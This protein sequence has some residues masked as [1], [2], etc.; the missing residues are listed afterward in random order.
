MFGPERVAILHEAQRH[1]DR[2]AL[3]QVR[4][5]CHGR[6]VLLLRLSF[7]FGLHASNRFEEV[8]AEFDRA[9][10]MLVYESLQGLQFGQQLDLDRFFALGEELVVLQEEVFLVLAAGVDVRDR[11]AA[12]LLRQF[13]VLRFAQFAADC[14]DLAVLQH[15]VPALCLLAREFGLRQF[16][17]GCVQRRPLVQDTPDPRHPLRP[18]ARLVC[19]HAREYDCGRCGQQLLSSRVVL[20]SDFAARSRQQTQQR[21]R[22][23]ALDPAN[24][25]LHFADVVLTKVEE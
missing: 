8:G 6:E 11:D 19:L 5:A 9:D 3:E 13:R 7:D 12:V 20:K 16:L 15:E 4:L 14:F 21:I 25:L 22:L 1:A 18:E 2:I 24:R 10:D 17:E 23:A